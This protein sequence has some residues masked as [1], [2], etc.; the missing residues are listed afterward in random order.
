LLDLYE[1]DFHL[2]YLQAAIKL[3]EK[4]MEIFEDKSGG[5]F[6]STAEGDPSLVMRIKEDYDGPSFRKLG[7]RL[8]PVAAGFR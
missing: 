5:G 3:T 6:F 2:P 7:G 8:Q 1:T 4:Q